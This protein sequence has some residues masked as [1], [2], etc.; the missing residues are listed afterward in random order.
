M[1]KRPRRR[2]VTATAAHERW[3]VV[4]Y[5][6]HLGAIDLAAKIEQ[7]AHRVKR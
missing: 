7:R 3:L 5:L 2:A 4:R 6:R 1:P